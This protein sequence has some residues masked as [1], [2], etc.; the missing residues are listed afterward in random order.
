MQHPL[1][2]DGIIFL[3]EYT[4]DEEK[5]FLSFQYVID[6]WELYSTTSESASEN[7]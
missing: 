6:T 2:E 1:W 4:I 7:G 5:R 3:E